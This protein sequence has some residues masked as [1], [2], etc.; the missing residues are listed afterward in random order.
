MDIKSTIGFGLLFSEKSQS[1]PD[2]T[3]GAV[4]ICPDGR[5]LAYS[6]EK[7]GFKRKKKI[8]SLYN[9]LLML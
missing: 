4:F 3:F 8:L 7:L 2:S 6:V 5:L 9:S 1:D